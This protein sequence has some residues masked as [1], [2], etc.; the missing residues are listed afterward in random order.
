M[1]LKE[2]KV[3]VLRGPNVNAPVKNESHGKK[4]EIENHSQKAKGSNGLPK[5]HYKGKQGTR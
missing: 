3:A 5:E 4:G 2:A 1:K